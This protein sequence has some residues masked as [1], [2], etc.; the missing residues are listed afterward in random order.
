MPNPQPYAGFLAIIDPFKAKIEQEV[1][2]YPTEADVQKKKL[3]GAERN[4]H[5]YAAGP[6]VI[7]MMAAFSV[8]YEELINGRTHTP[9][10]ATR[11]YLLHAG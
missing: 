8:I 2:I 5:R 4:V 7:K 9:L 6:I 10:D 3:Y 1:N 11:L